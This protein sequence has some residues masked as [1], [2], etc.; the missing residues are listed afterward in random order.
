MRAELNA[1]ADTSLRVTLEGVRN[2]MNVWLDTTD[3]CPNC[4]R[5]R[6]AE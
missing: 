2:A 4:R 6:F 5:Q 1:P 3:L